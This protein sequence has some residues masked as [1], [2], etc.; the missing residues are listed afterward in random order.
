[1]TTV[2]IIQARM[3]STRLPGKVLTDLAGEPALVHVVER[4]RRATTLDAVVVATTAQPADESIVQLCTERGYPCVRGSEDDVL[5]RYYRAAQQYHA[6]VVVRITADCPLIEPAI[7]DHVVQTFRRHR[8]DYV[9]NSLPPRTYP[10]GL[11]V[12]VFRFAALARAWHEDTNPT[13]REH[14]TPYIRRN[15]ERFSLH[16]V[17]HDGDY[18]AMRWTVD[19]EEDLALVRHIYEHFGNN[20]FSWQDVLMLLEQHPEWLAIN[21]HIQQKQV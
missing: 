19:T 15:P 18:S 4:T 1:M 6:D 12:E 14:V 20:T 3:G 10:R 2:A 17:A 9:S 8:C 21:Q 13:W 7:I 5:D 16:A 11:D